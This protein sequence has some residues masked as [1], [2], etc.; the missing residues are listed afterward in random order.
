MCIAAVSRRVHPAAK[1]FFM[2]LLLS[3]IVNVTF[4]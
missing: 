3:K 1:T 2:E 4:I